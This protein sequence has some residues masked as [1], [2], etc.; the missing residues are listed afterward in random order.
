MPKMK[1]HTGMAKR[2]RVTGA[3][4]IVKQ[5][6]NRVHKLEWKS[7]RRKRRLARRDEISAA[8]YRRVK[9]LLGR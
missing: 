5:Q 4:K 6:A 3:G 8:D 9:K 2:S 1:T 7:S